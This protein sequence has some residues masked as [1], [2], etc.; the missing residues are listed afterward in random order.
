MLRALALLSL[1]LVRMPAIAA[2]IFEDGSFD[3]AQ[4]EDT[5]VRSPTAGACRE[6]S[7]FPLNCADATGSGPCGCAW[8][9]QNPFGGFG[10]TYR[11]IR[12]YVLGDGQITWYHHLKDWTCPERADTSDVGV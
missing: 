11:T 7:F 2:V 3:P 8:V 12:Q 9:R 5:Q 6:D 1:V 10:G 4:W